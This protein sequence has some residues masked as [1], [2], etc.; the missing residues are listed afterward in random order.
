MKQTMREQSP[1]LFEAVPPC[2]FITDV[3]TFPTPTALL[4]AVD[5]LRSEANAL[6]LEATR[7]EKG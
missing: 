3:P 5:D 1:T 4:K 6:L 7:N 2:L